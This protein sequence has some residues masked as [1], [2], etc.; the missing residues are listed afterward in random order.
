MIASRGHRFLVAFVLMGLGLGASYLLQRTGSE[1][2]ALMVAAAAISS[3]YGGT[4][5]SLLS[6]AVGWG[7]A[8]YLLAGDEWSWSPPSRDELVRW[9]VPLVASLVVIWVS[10][11][12][13]RI[14]TRAVEH[15][16]SAEQA[17]FATEAVQQLTSELSFDPEPRAEQPRVGARVSLEDLAQPGGPLG[18]LEAAGKVE[19]RYTPQ[20]ALLEQN[21]A[22]GAALGQ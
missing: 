3:W 16:S 19:R 8:W 6:T 21:H 18:A 12:L 9:L 7:A 22:P 14:G 1:T 20:K 5:P 2:Y 11:A 17:R 4:L 15:A 13:R 10:W